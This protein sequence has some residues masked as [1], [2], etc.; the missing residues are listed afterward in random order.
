MST[1][2]KAGIAL[3]L[4]W[5]VVA[6]IMWGAGSQKV[7]PDKITDYV[8]ANPLSDLSSEA[9]REKLVRKVATKVNALSFEQR[10]E[11]RDAGEQPLRP[12]FES[13]NPS[14]FGLFVEITAGPHFDSVMRAFNEMEPE[15]RQRIAQE[16]V[17]QLQENDRMRPDEREQLEDEGVEIFEKISSEGLR[18]YYQEA[19]ADTKLDLAPVLEELQRVMQRPGGPKWKRQS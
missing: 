4:L 16:T 15:E 1:L 5:A 11:M 19:S 6:A 18:A 10:R 9:D 13:M 7:T 2:V 14:E 17:R 3:A 12:F 8:A